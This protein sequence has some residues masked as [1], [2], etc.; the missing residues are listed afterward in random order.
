M[1]YWSKKS[2][3]L[4]TEG[5]S[6][7]LGVDTSLQWVQGGC[8]GQIGEEVATAGVFFLDRCS[9]QDWRRQHHLGVQKANFWSLPQTYKIRTCGN[10]AWQSGFNK[11]L[12]VRTKS[13]QSCLTLCNP[14]DCSPPGSS[15]HGI[16]QARILEWVAMPSSRGSS[17][18]RNRTLVSYISCIGRQV[19]H[20]KH[21]LGS[22]NS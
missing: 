4:E 20:L 14:M 6:G 8:G 9:F 5:F 16:L 11:P 18:P 17:Q 13:L 12:C 3:N 15:V 2:Q 1:G 19:L 10:G 7:R 21:R 22:T